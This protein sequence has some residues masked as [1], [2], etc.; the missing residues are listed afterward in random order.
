MDKSDAHDIPT[1][2]LLNADE[3]LFVRDIAK[4]RGISVSSYFRQKAN[5][6]RK[7]LAQETLL[8]ESAPINTP[9]PTQDIANLLFEFAKFIKAK[10]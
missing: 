5:D 3:Y 1:T 6:E 10:Q 7:Q 4:Q 8:A 2:V 9:E